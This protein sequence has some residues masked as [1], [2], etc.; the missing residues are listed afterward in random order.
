MW[1]YR[2]SQL[3]KNKWTHVGLDHLNKSQNYIQIDLYNLI[4]FFVNTSVANTHKVLGI[5]KKKR[6]S[7]LS[8]A[9]MERGQ[10]CGKL[11]YVINAFSSMHNC[12]EIKIVDL[13]CQSNLCCIDDAV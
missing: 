11:C 8:F 4:F 5:K 2:N 9:W 1:W 3:N 7:M 10:W 6:D 13:I 12:T